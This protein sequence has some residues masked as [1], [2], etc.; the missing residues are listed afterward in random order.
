VGN[1]EAHDVPIGRVADV[2][3]TDGFTGNVLL[4]GIEGTVAAMSEALGSA[5]GRTALRRYQPDRSGGAV[6]LGVDG[7]V[8]V[9]HGSS[10]P[11]AVAACIAL[12]ADS[13]R[14]ALLPRLRGTLRSPE[15]PMGSGDGE[16]HE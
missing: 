15:E 10:G 14:D 5:E 9:G 6:L 3:V 16:R 11:P 12:A 13:V 7:V 2:V 1:V 4:K 8:V